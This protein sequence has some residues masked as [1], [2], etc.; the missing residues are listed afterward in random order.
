M[1]T[2]PQNIAPFRDAYL[3][4]IPIP[5]Y[6]DKAGRVWLDPLWHRDLK[7]HFGYL[8]RLRLASPRLLKDE[9]PDL[10]PLTDAERGGLEIVALPPQRSKLE[11]IRGLF[12]TLRILWCEIGKAETVHSGIVGWP[13]PLG[14]FAYAIALV[15]KRKIVL[16]IESAPWRLAP[17]TRKT[18]TRFFRQWVMETLGRWFTNRA[19]LVIATHKGYLRSLAT[20]PHGITAVIPASW[21][22]EDNLMKPEDAIQNWKIKT[23]Q[24]MRFIFAGRL[25]E[26]KGIRVL[27]D[28]ASQL[29]IIAD[30]PPGI[31][32]VGHGD[33]LNDCRLAAGRLPFVRLLE[34]VP[35][36]ESFFSLVRQYHAVIVPALSDEQPRIIYDA[37]SQAVPVIAS[38]TEGNRDS[39]KDIRTG[40]LLPVGDASALAQ[41][42]MKAASQPALLA[43]MGMNALHYAEGKTHS[44]MHRARAAILQK[45][46][47]PR[48]SPADFSDER[49]S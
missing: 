21:L 40:W 23:T 11:W 4:V 19:D 28:A 43:E 32:I 26:D 41:Q 34:P 44:E 36:G 33:L 38:D 9:I 16:V 27:L 12:E 6:V 18:F 3:M 24:P 42:L 14:W 47:H 39:V 8:P 5:Y 45:L 1:T 46:Y 37:Y 20:R 22:D 13:V 10:V 7:H 29:A 48:A 30:S 31:D 25:T 35:Y 17:S 49:V 15:R 2:A